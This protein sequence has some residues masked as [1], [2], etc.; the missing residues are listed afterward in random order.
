MTDELNNVND[1]A[2]I[3]SSDNI[4]TNV[5]GYIINAQ[6]QVYSA[7][8]A[9]MVEAYWNIGKTI[10]E[11]CGKIHAVNICR[12]CR[13]RKSLRELNLADFEKLEEE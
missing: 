12:T 7:V 10:Y 8:N 9:A 11:V 3:Q 1:M 6:R 2:E 13:Q 4:Y 5:R